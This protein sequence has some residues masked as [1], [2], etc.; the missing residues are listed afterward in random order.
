MLREM[1]ETTVKTLA[2]APPKELVASTSYLVKRLGW[3][4][5]ERSM[6]AFEASGLNPQHYGVL[7]LLEEKPPETQAAIADSLGYDRSHLVGLLDE[8]EEQ[9]LVE[10]KRDTADRRRHLVSLTPAGKETLG[11]LRS[12]M[13][14]LEK[15]FLAPLDAAERQALHTLLLRLASHHDARFASHA[16]AGN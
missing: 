9:G 6:E 11:Q 7:L 12:I 15:D 3:D 16:S 13:R 5:K 2:P 1:T 4:F 14:R 8:L 10:R